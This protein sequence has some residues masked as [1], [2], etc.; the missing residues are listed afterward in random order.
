MLAAAFDACNATR[1]L[2]ADSA[3]W[4]VHTYSHN[5]IHGPATKLVC[6]I[7][8]LK[9]S[10]PVALV[11]GQACVQTE[12]GEVVQQS[13]GVPQMPE[14]GISTLTTSERLELFTCAQLDA[15]PT[16]PQHT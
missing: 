2:V 4:S 8:A 6:S 7:P 15:Q 12:A 9:H 16:L 11:A 5:C 13:L 14:H 3:A 10:V 1:F